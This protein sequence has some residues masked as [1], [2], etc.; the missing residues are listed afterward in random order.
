MASRYVLALDEGSSSTRAVLFDE[1]GIARAEHSE[2]IHA[3]FPNP[4][5]VELDPIAVW[6][7]VQNTIDAVL[8]QSG[9]SAADIASVGITTHRETIVIWDRVT[10][11]PV[12][13]AV[14]WSSKQTD[15]IIKSWQDK[16]FAPE[17]RARTGVRNDSYFSAGKI[18]WLLENVAGVRDRASRGE[19]CAG[20]MDSWLLFKLT[21]G[22]SHLTDLSA[23]SR[24][25]LLSIQSGTWDSDLIRM[26]DLELALMPGL[27][28]S[29]AHF[30]EVAETVIPGASQHP[31]P[32]FSILGDQMAGL[33]GQACINPGDAKN[34]FGTAG[35]LTVNV[36]D[37]PRV[38]DGMT[39]SVAW[40]FNDQITYEAEGVVFFSGKAIAWLRDNLGIIEHSAQAESLAESVSDNGGVYLVPA[41]SGLCD[42]YWD[43]D[44][45]GAIFGLQL[46]TTKAHLVRAGL[47]SMAYQTAANV[48]TLRQGGVEVS[49]LKIDGGAVRNNWLCQ[50]QADVLGIPVLRP[51][52]PEKTALGAAHVAGAG[53][54][55]WALEDISKRWELDRQFEPEI[56]EDQRLSLLAGWDDAVMAARSLPPRRF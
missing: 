25:A 27:R 36:G 38:M 33:F 47:E 24:T 22:K 23:A 18:S 50:F 11:L 4:G 5:W 35:V 10:G 6:Q 26:L 7:A 55:L 12:H 16:G 56:S 31:I 54:G 17:I 45:R 15:Q 49:S 20:T 46:D 39:S 14:M 42:P 43:R 2:P 28:N 13:N 21:G 9:A 3:A 53:A 1:Q 48:D 44:V 8:Q 29:N 51:K 52:D 41:F 34:T 32:V 40:S 37:E 30:G 19:L